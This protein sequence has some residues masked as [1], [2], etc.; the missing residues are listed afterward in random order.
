VNRKKLS[1][2][3]P[4]AIIGAAILGLAA[5][6]ALSSPASAHHPIVSGEGGCI[7]NGQWEVNW[8]VVNSE[9]DLEGKV[10]QVQPGPVG[11]IV[12]DAVL[13]KSG[14]GE[15]TGKQ[16]LPGSDRTAKLKVKV[17]WKRDGNVITQWADG[18][19]H[20]R[21]GC[22]QKPTA[23][24]QSECDG[25]VVVTLDNTKGEGDVNLKVSATG[26]EETHTVPA[27]QTKGGIVVPAGAG[28]IKVTRG[29][30]VIATDTWKNPGNCGVPEDKV[31]STCEELIY[32]LINPADGREVTVTL[33]PNKGEPQTITAK[34]GETVE[35]RFPGS[36]G[37]EVVPSVGDVKGDPFTW[38]PEDCATPAPTTPPPPG[39]G[40]GGPELP[41]TGVAAGGIAGGALL[42]LAIGAVLFFVARRRR[43][44]FT[45]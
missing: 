1:L 35:A 37:L 22:A 41:V 13:P 18:E 30:R 4:T 44:T 7:V 19:A 33:T 42:L 20:P 11:D 10:V 31:T 38:E 36:E 12:D 45:A 27:G 8:T 6:V 5:S 34:P 32:T 17:K 21:K 43:T 23:A 3:R 16:T 29:Q 28:E 9:D 14:E 15:L 39:G 25:T 26:F 2:R 24:F 40:G